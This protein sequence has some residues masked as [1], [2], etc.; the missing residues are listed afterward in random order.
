MKKASFSAEWE[1]KDQRKGAKAQR[2]KGFVIK[3]LRLCVD[4]LF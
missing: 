3:T 4:L 2:R 1:E